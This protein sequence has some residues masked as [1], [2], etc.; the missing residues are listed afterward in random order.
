[1]SSPLLAAT[2]LVTQVGK[3]GLRAVDNVDIHLWAGEVLGIVG[4]SGSGKTTLARTLLGQQQES[5]G[6]ICLHQKRVSGVE[7]RRARAARRVI[8]YVHQD[9]AAALDPWWRI[10]NTLHETLRVSGVRNSDERKE[11]IEQMLKAVGLHTGVLERYPHELSGGQIRRIGLARILSLRPEIVILDE[12]TAGL[13]LSV[14]ANVLRLF[15]DMQAQFNLSYIMVSHDLSVVRLMCD[16]VAVMYLGKI[17][18]VAPSQQLFE[19]PAHPYTRSMLGAAPRVDP[20][21]QV[22]SSTLNGDPPS[23]MKTPDGCR[24]RT[25]CDHATD[26]C[27]RHV[28]ELETVSGEHSVACLRWRDLTSFNLTRSH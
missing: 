18:E 26:A 19:S 1:M 23:L 13:D 8:Q 15:K 24:F 4:E 9:Q 5:A 21:R 22:Q 17:V 3:A 11:R 27:S 12:P 14:Q 10:G 25:R 2:G 16:R 7:P 28:P 20:E 6:E